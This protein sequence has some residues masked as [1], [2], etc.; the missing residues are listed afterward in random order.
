[1]GLDIN[2]RF[3]GKQKISK[4]SRNGRHWVVPLKHIQVK[5]QRNNVYTFTHLTSFSRKIAFII[6]FNFFYQ[7]SPPKFFLNTF[8]VSKDCSLWLR[9]SKQNS[10]MLISGLKLYMGKDWCKIW[11]NLP[12]DLF[13]IVIFNMRKMKLRSK[14]RVIVTKHFL[15]LNDHIRLLREVTYKL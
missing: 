1:M 6:Y 5:L 13:H 3:W 11:I 10:Q 8:Y 7:I 15:K 14:N 4:F 12:N 9:S 2:D